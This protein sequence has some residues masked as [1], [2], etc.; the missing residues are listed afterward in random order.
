MR[1]LALCWQWG[2]VL[3]VGALLDLKGQADGGGQVS[4]LPPATED[5]FSCLEGWNSSLWPDYSSEGERSV[6]T[7]QGGC[8]DLCLLPL[9]IAVFWVSFAG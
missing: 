3:A 6:G 9:L 4:C 5:R 7:V 2:S 1:L 8:Q